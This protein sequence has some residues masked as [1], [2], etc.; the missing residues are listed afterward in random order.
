VYEMIHDGYH[1]AVVY[2]DWHLRILEVQNKEEE[3]G[4]EGLELISSSDVYSKEM[5]VLD[6]TRAM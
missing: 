5:M 2:S 6:S 1:S 4:E 3:E